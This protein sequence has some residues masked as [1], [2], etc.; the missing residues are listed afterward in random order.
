MNWQSATETGDSI[1]MIRRAITTILNNAVAGLLFISAAS[2][3]GPGQLQAPLVIQQLRLDPH[4][5]LE[6]LSPAEIASDLGNAANNTNA[7][8]VGMWSI[9][10]LSEGNTSH[11]P[12][13]PDGAM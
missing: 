9:Q 10:F 2:A 13:I 8:I 12:S 3:C 1:K 5:A 6:S 4:N 11:N 7:S